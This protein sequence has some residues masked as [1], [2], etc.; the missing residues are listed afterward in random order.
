MSQNVWLVAKCLAMSSLHY[1][2]HGNR[3]HKRLQ[4]PSAFAARLFLGSF[5]RSTARSFRAFAARIVDAVE[6]EAH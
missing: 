3:N 1:N 4:K 6:A 5:G 2:Q